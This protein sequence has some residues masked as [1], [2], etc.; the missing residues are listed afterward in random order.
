[1]HQGVY[2]LPAWRC[3]LLTTSALDLLAGDASAK[4]SPWPA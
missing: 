4:Q 2:P 1:M 3:W